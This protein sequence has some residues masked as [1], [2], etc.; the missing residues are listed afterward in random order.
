MQENDYQKRVNDYVTSRN[1]F[2]NYLKEGVLSQNDF[3]AINSR[4]LAKYK[5]SEKSVY[6]R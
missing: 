2:E 4:L 6:N 5:L 1:I 3:D